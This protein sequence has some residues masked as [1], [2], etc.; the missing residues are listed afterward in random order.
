MAWFEKKLDCVA[1]VFFRGTAAPR[2]KEF[3]FLT[4]QGFKFTKAPPNADAHWTYGLSHPQYGE[5]VFWAPREMTPPPATVI[6]MDPRLRQSEREELYQGRSAI[7]VSMRGER[8]HVLRDRK[9]MLRFIRALMGDDGVAGLDPGCHRFWSRVALDEELTHDADLDIFDLYTFHAIYDP[10]AGEGDGAAVQG[11]PD[12]DGPHKTYWLHTHGLAPLGG[13]EFNVLNPT[14]AFDENM[15]DLLRALALAIVEGRVK[16][17]GEAFELC[18][19]GAIRLIPSREF[20]AKADRRG[21]EQW[22]DSVDEDHLDG[23]AVVCDPGTGL[24]DRWFRRK[25]R[26]VGYLSRPLP[27]RM[28]AMLSEASTTLGRERAL[29]TFPVFVSLFREIEGIDNNPIVKLGCPT[30]DGG[31]EHIW[32]KVHGCTNDSID[33]ECLNTPFNV[34]DLKQGDRKR[35]PAEMLSDWTIQT[36]LGS[37]NPRQMGLARQIREHKPALLALFKVF[38]G[39]DDAAKAAA[40][41]TLKMLLN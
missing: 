10:P 13:V 19:V 12:E 41:M 25:P 17:N 5:A 22:V 38:E 8:N 1:A 36:P 6:D 30:S 32:F 4:Q 31:H 2:A 34:A 21:I 26:P 9:R 20:R 33:G 35:Y 11:G 27:D 15:Q 28:M 29:A 40:A 18:S 24:L 3:E 7:A 14:S 37:I 39:D 16:A 23:N